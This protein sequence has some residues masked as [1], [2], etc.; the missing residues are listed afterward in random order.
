MTTEII[1]S[2]V[3]TFCTDR[4]ATPDQLAFTADIIQIVRQGLDKF[5]SPLATKQALKLIHK[6]LIHLL[7][8][9]NHV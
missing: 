4:Q 2:S 7:E 6:D 1:R 9:D 3:Q 8:V 5:D